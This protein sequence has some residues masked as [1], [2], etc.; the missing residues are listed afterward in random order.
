MGRLW[1]ITSMNGIGYHLVPLREH[2]RWFR[3]TDPRRQLTRSD[4]RDL[5][6]TMF[7][8]RTTPAD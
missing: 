5:R 1:R 6:R 8:E 3:R 7:R 4:L 2:A